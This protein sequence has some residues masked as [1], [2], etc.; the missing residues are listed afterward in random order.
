MTV[1]SINPATREVMWSFRP[2]TKLRGPGRC[3]QGHEMFVQMEA[4]EFL[5]CARFHAQD[6]LDN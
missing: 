6:L 5:R 3:G 4:Y 2:L 1:K